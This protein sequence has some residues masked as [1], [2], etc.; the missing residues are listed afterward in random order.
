M[1]HLGEA[2]QPHNRS[3]QSNSLDNLYGFFM[4]APLS[5]SKEGREEEALLAACAGCKCFIDCR[6]PVSFAWYGLRLH[7]ERSPRGHPHP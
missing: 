6:G 5:L 1:L 4:C 2:T 3:D 7:F